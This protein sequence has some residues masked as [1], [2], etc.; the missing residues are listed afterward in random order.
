MSE[1]SDMYEGGNG[2]NRKTFPCIP[3]EPS[4]PRNFSPSKLLLFT[5]C[6]DVFVVLKLSY[7]FSVYCYFREYVHVFIPCIC[8]LVICLMF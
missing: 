8:L 6:E 2:K 7:R 5:V 1:S 4:K 3:D